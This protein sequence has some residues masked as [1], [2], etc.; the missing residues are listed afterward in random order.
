MRCQGRALINVHL[1]SMLECS[2]IELPPLSVVQ[3]FLCWSDIQICT[4]CPLFCQQC[5]VMSVVGHVLYDL[6]QPLMSV[7]DMTDADDNSHFSCRSKISYT[8]CAMESCS[9]SAKRGPHAAVHN[10]K[11]LSLTIQTTE[12]YSKAI[13]C[14]ADVQGMLCC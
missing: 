2:P 9:R 5:H 4:I 10:T 12:P 14:L 11:D 8:A 13:H 6:L 7:D 3:L 1:L